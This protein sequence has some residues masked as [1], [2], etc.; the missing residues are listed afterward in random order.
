MR[1]DRYA[2]DKMIIRLA[3]LSAPPLQKPPWEIGRTS[4]GRKTSF[5]YFRPRFTHGLRHAHSQAAPGLITDAREHDHGERA[6]R[7]PGGEVGGE[8][9]GAAN[10]HQA[11][12]C[13]QFITRS[14]VTARP[15]PTPSA[16]AVVATK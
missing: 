13:R 14:P 15:M 4:A 9:Q 12:R 8:D 2:P 11:L 10:D 7:D 1:I 3:I 5:L 16:K 6:E